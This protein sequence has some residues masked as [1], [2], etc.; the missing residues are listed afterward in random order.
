MVRSILKMAFSFNN[1]IYDRKVII[2]LTL[3]YR[4]IFGLVPR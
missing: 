1:W 4:N 2:Q 3:Q